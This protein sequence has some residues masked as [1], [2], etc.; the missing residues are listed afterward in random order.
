M[1][2]E[3][4]EMKHSCT[5]PFKG[6]KERKLIEHNKCWT[7]MMKFLIIGETMTSNAKTVLW[8]YFVVLC[9]YVE[10]NF[11]VSEVEYGLGFSCSSERTQQTTGKLDN[12]T[13]DLKMTTTID[14]K[15]KRPKMRLGA[16]FYESILREKNRAGNVGAS[17]QQAKK[18]DLEIAE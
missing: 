5:M 12:E 9:E 10:N 15:L 17:H 14:G 4:N 16:L 18:V 8:K 11:I 3:L 7:L 13:R 2:V 1:E 6:S